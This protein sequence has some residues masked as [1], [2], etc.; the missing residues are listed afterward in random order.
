MKLSDKQKKA[1]LTA[2]LVLAGAFAEKYAQVLELVAQFAL[3]FF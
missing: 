3:G 1:I 2:T